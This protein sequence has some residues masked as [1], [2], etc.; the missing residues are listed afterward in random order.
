MIFLLFSLSP[1]FLSPSLFLIAR[2][3]ES[4]ENVLK[5]FSSAERREGLEGSSGSGRKRD[6]DADESEETEEKGSSR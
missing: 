1:F 3:R 6:E 5:R 4:G 2:R